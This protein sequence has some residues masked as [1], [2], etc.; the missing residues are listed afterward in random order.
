MAIF[1]NKQKTVLTP[2]IKPTYKF[3][4]AYGDHGHINVSAAGYVLIYLRECTTGYNTR[5]D[6]IFCIETH[7]EYIISGSAGA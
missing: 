7:S 4:L 6:L 1:Y 2:G 5:R 3:L